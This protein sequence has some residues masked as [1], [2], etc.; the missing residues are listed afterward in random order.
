MGEDSLHH[1]GLPLTPSAGAGRR[2]AAAGRRGHRPRP[3]HPGQP[4][5]GEPPRERPAPLSRPIRL[6]NER[7]VTDFG[8]AGLLSIGQLPE[9]VTGDGS[10]K[11][12]APALPGDKFA[13]VFARVPGS[14]LVG[15]PGQ[16]E[17][18]CA[19]FTN[20]RGFRSVVWEWLSHAAYRRPKQSSPGE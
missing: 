3:A 9:A 20:D 19:R 13:L 17:D 12:A 15:R 18:I 4:A 11:E 14:L 16:N 8:G 5:A 2:V 7:F 1:N 10:L 6:S